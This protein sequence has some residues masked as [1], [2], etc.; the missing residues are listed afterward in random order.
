MIHFRKALLA[1][2]NVGID[3][4]T[5]PT[6]AKG[7]RIINWISIVAVLTG[8]PH[9]FTYL[10]IG[11]MGL[12]MVQVT[13]LL[14]LLSALLWNSR[15][16]YNIAKWMVIL[17]ANLNFVLTSSVFGLLSGEHL[18]AI[19]IVLLSFVIFD[20]RQKYQLLIAVIF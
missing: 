15:R 12:S 11:G 20:L 18:I 10:E 13:T 8:L 17:P 3:D 4:Q 6:E 7:V 2:S 14:F 16:K 19:A 9:V 5:D 1:I